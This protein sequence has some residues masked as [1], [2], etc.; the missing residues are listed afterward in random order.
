MWD[1]AIVCVSEASL[2]EGIKAPVLN[3]EIGTHTFTLKDNTIS[4]Y[5]HQDNP[6][7]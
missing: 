3:K 5:K 1:E 2:K 6:F 7:I 4:I